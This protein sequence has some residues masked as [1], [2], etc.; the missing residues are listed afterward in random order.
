MTENV[1]HDSGNFG[2]DSEFDNK[3]SVSVSFQDDGRLLRFLLPF[4]LTS[5][6]SD[7]YAATIRTLH[8]IQP[9]CSVFSG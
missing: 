4:S 7:R 9:H 8:S 2:D 3:S 5:A 6:Y 1:V